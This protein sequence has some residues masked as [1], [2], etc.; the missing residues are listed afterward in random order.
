MPSLG[1]ANVPAVTRTASALFEME[2]R[3]ARPLRERD[4]FF[5]HAAASIP[6]TKAAGVKNDGT[7]PPADARTYRPEEGSDD[8]A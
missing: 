2:E 7:F 1:W 4:R 8:E 6:G 3:T 5:S